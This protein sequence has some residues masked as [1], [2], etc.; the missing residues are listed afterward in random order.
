M[1]DH[2]AAEAMHVDSSSSEGRS[3]QKTS[4]RLDLSHGIHIQRLEDLELVIVS[5]ST[6]GFSVAQAQLLGKLVRD[7]ASG[8]SWPC[9]FLVFDLASRGTAPAKPSREFETFV[10]ELSNLIFQVP[11]LSVAWVRHDLS[12]PDLELALACSMLVGEAG[13]RLTFDVDLVDSLR[14]YALLAHKI[15]F[16]QAERLMETGTVLSASA[17]HDLMILH[18]VVPSGEGAEGIRLFVASRTRR[19][20][21]A[22]GLYRAQRIAMLGAV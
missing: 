17:A 20:N 4:I 16:V 6:A 5:K 15:G 1:L 19:H 21:S 13:A 2:H 11:V 8:N 10:E 7:I 3:A 12:G 22:C 9:K 14:T 18:S